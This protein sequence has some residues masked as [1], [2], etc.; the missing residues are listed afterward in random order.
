MRKT[1]LIRIISMAAAFFL[2]IGFIPVY[3]SEEATVSVRRRFG[4]DLIIGE[5]KQLEVIK[6]NFQEDDIIHWRS[7]NEKVCTV[8]ENGVVTALSRGSSTVYASLDNGSETYLY[9]FVYNE[10]EAIA[11]TDE[12]YLAIAGQ[13]VTTLSAKVT[14][15]ALDERI[16]YTAEDPEIATTEGNF[17]IGL[18]AGKTRVKAEIPGYEA[19]AYADVEILEG[20]YAEYINYV[21]GPDKTTVAGL[22]LQLEYTLGSSEDYSKTEFEDE[23]V[24]WTMDSDAPDIGTISDEG[25]FHAASTGQTNVYATI[26]N[27]QRLSYHIYVITPVESIEF[28]ETNLYS[29]DTGTDINL[30][31][32]IKYGPQEAGTQDLE[33]ASSDE[34]VLTVNDSGTAKAVG[35]GTAVV[36]VSARSN[37]E[38]SASHEFKVFD[39]VAPAGIKPVSDPDQVYYLNYTYVPLQIEYEPAE[40]N[41]KTNWQTS[42]VHILNVSG[43]ETYGYV[44][45]VSAGTAYVTA[46]S[47]INSLI[48]TRFNI[49]V[50]EGDPEPCT[51]DTVLTIGKYEDGAYTP[52][53][54]QVNPD[55]YTLEKGEDYML[56]YRFDSDVCIPDISKLGDFFADSQSIHLVRML[57]FSN[58][59]TNDHLSAQVSLLIH[60][61]DACEETFKIG[62]REITFIAEGDPGDVAK[63]EITSPGQI[64][65]FEETLQLTAL[66]KPENSKVEWSSSNPSIIEVDENG[67]CTAKHR[68]GTVKITAKAGNKSAAVNISVKSP[69]QIHGRS[70]SLEGKIGVNFYL[71]AD[72]DKNEDIDIILSMGDDIRRTRYTDGLPGTT[73]PSTKKFSFDVSAK[74]M[75]DSIMINAER[76]DGS[77]K[78]IQDPEGNYYHSGCSYTVNDYLQQAFKTGSDQLKPLAGAMV[79]YGKYAQ[80]YFNY[81][82]NEDVMKADD[83]SHI[84]A[85]TFVEYAAKQSGSVNGLTYAGASLELESDTGFRLYFSLAEGHDIKDYTFSLGEEKIDVSRKAGG[86]LYYVTID[87]IAAQDLD[88]MKTITVTAG[89]DALNIQYCP[90]SYTYTALSSEKA[91]DPIKNVCRALYIYNQQSKAYFNN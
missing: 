53:D 19:H 59:S 63:L 32:Y 78:V 89:T 75:R 71:Y 87:G 82:V 5:T 66:T 35:P 62:S 10:P 40:G 17:L 47:A 51:Y 65:E 36:T 48:S 83:L 22:D 37:P 41:P 26:T 21:G 38:V 74:Q 34:T 12:D 55:V 49:T 30:L 11:F 20:D 80:Q 39:Y 13:R 16:V 57:G 4:N 44:S 3:A 46:G 73:S 67:L 50:K 33:Y 79:T 72:L 58:N 1:I 28:D 25:I 42:N 23:H 76:S 84:T 77:V 43:S 69:V 86:N 60:V 29:L 2:C 85:E 64:M 91:G 8:D 56:V 31:S 7:S 18:K 70:L 68:F 88:K 81:N 6:K 27:R 54:P 61:D 9:V 24:I 90:L 15:G 14:N 45:T 52:K